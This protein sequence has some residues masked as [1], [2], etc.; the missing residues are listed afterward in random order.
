LR[1]Q[2]DEAEKT[3]SLTRRGAP[4]Q[5]FK[6][7]IRREGEAVWLEGPFDGAPIRVRLE[8][9]EER[10]ATLTLNRFRWINEYP[11]NR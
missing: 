6:L 2:L 11:D 8:R 3:L 10:A 1:G 7:A 9:G 4:P 5:V